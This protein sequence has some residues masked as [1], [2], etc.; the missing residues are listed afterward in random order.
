MFKRTIAIILALSFGAVSISLAAETPRQTFAREIK[1]NVS[2]NVLLCQT[3]DSDGYSL[4]VICD[5][6]FIAGLP[7][8]ERDKTTYAGSLLIARGF[9]LANCTYANEAN[10]KSTTMCFF[11]RL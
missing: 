8:A 3:V 2:S 6:N 11:S 9:K 5:G 10:R 4:Q 7:A 1:E